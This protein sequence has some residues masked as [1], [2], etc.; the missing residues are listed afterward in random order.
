MT[1]VLILRGT[2]L[3]SDMQLKTSLTVVQ[4]IKMLNTHLLQL[5]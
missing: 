3:I 4:H 1:N 2:P 5:W